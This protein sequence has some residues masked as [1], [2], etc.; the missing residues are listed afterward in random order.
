[1]TIFGFLGGKRWRPR[2]PAYFTKAGPSSSK[3]PRTVPYHVWP[4]SASS[5]LCH[6]TCRLVPVVRM[7]QFVVH[8]L[9]CGMVRVRCDGRCGGYG[10]VV[11]KGEGEARGARLIRA[12]SLAA[13]MTGD[14]AGEG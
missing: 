10:G 8:R 9:W 7:C 13:V 2:C 14:D 11:G 12:A 3:G 5:A 1:M 4:L 6:A